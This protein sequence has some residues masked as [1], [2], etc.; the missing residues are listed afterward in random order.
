MTD[1]PLQQVLTQDQLAHT[2]QIPARTLE[3]WRTRSYGPPF[4]RV[5]KRVRYRA[6]DVDAWLSSQVAA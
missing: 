1:S 4:I 5:G 3:D 2:L 6:S